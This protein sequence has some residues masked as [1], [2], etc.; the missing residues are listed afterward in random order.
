MALFKK[1]KGK[2]KSNEEHKSDDGFIILPHK[3]QELSEGAKN[4]LKARSKP[5]YGIADAQ[6]K[7][8]VETQ[9]W[10][11]LEYS[12]YDWWMFPWAGN[13]NSFGNKYKLQKSDYFLLLNNDEFIQN[14]IF[15]VN[16]MIS[17]KQNGV[18]AMTSNHVSSRRV[19]KII[20]SIT[21]FKNA[22]KLSKSQHFETLDNCLK[23]I[24]SE[25]EALNKGYKGKNKLNLKLIEQRLKEFG[26]S[27]DVIIK[28]K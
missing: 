25:W 28:E 24:Y 17:A 11:R 5:P 27:N 16:A 12:H 26:I 2:K 8:I 14:Y 13:S 10:K 6:Y 18:N 15:G 21:S 9:E 4:V 20:V 3:D 7:K 1:K 19:V 23:L 22:A